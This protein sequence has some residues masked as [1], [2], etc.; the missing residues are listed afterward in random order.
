[1]K[2][3]LTTTLFCLPIWL[4]GQ[5]HIGEQLAQ[6]IDREGETP[7]RALITLHDQLNTDSL[8]SEWQQN[9]V[10]L[11]ERRQI[12]LESLDRVSAASQRRVLT[13]LD[14]QE[15]SYTLI[16]SLQIVNMLAVVVHPEVITKL[17]DHPDVRS[18]IL[19]KS[20]FQLIEPVEMKPATQRSE[21]SSEPGLEV[22]GARQMWEMGYTGRGRMAFSVD[23]GI[24]PDHPALKQRWKGHR[25]PLDEC[26]LPWDRI[27]PGDKANSH[28]SH[29]MGTVLG[30]DTMTNDTIGAA[31]N[32]YFIATD[33]VVSNAAD[34]RPLSDYV[35]TYQ[36]CLN[37]DGDIQ[38]HDDVP[39]AINNSWG[40]QPD[41]ESPYCDEDMSQMYQVLEM[42]GIAN[43]SS[44]GNDGPLPQT[45]SVPHNISINEVNSFTL[46]SVNGNN[47]TLPIS[48][49]SSRGPGQCGGDGSLLIKPE[50]V[51]PGQLVRSCINQDEYANYS[52]TSMACP[53]AV[54]AVLLLKEAFPN[55]PGNIILEALYYTAI[56]LG[57]PGEDNTYGM[58]V[59]NVFDAYNYLVDEGHIPVPPNQSPHDLVIAE[60]LS[61]VQ[62]TT[63]NNTFSS[64]I[65]VK[66][67]GTE[68]I[69]GFQ[70][71]F[72]LVGTT[73]I[74]LDI[75]ETLQPNQELDVEIPTISTEE[76]GIV[77]IMYRADLYDDVDEIDF[78]NNQIIARVT[79]K[80]QVSVPFTETFETGFDPALW[81]ILNPDG[82]KTWESFETSGLP[83]SEQSARVPLYSYSLLLSQKDDLIG[84]RVTMPEDGNVYLSFDLAYQL[85]SGPTI[86]HDTLIVYLATGCDLS[87]VHQIY[88]EGGVSLSTYIVNT[89]DFVPDTSNHW[90]TEVIDIT[91]YI[92]NEVVIP[93]FQTVNRRGNNL[94]IDNVSIYQEDNPLSVGE[95]KATNILLYP[96]P[97]GD[98]VFVEVAGS[99]SRVK[100]DLFDATGRLVFSEQFSNAAQRLE[101]STAHLTRGIYVVRLETDT[102][103]EVIRMVKE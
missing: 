46:G 51:A 70:I 59:I 68:T 69:S 34:V 73:P 98:R 43:L 18:I 9:P 30:L 83:D 29:T 24:W 49:F 41:E 54:G 14:N 95:V 4:C 92:D 58:G 64:L 85:R 8:K 15:Q 7:V 97:A 57:E 94:Y 52:G 47:S 45:M 99:P 67:G 101:M 22:I 25:Y 66:N 84:P 38:T 12:I 33:P 102:T 16:R 19:D 56:D 11:N 39:D 42:T 79:I 89:F 36:W 61:P 28:G 20:P 96:N 23:T 60:V 90:R 81:H 27:T 80:E 10:P 88:Y 76:T 63:C 74:I 93:I 32:A 35:F 65:R 75:D 103:T 37:P 6:R 48:D 78:H 1:M 53:H 13:F 86:H 40:R 2:N 77:E 21:N 87:E 26:W 62:N 72:G 100:I 31:F 82:S 44:A 3:F 55:L 71:S 5:A 50:V 91:E 17:A